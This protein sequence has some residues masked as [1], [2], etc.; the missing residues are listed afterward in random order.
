MIGVFYV[1]ERGMKMSVFDILGPVMVGPSSSHTA[2]AVNIG[3]VARQVFG[4]K[5]DKAEITLYGS[6]ADTYKG[7]GTDRA[8]VAGIMGFKTDD[9]RI[10][11]AL[12][13]A[14]EE[15]LLI[16][17]STSKEGTYH[18]NTVRIKLS[19]K[20]QSSEI[21]GVSIGGGR[22]RIREV[23]KFKVDISGIYNTL[24]CSYPDQMG[25]IAKVSEILASEK[26]NIATMSVSR[27]K[28]YQIALMVVEVDGELPDQ[29]VNQ[30]KAMPYFDTVKA[31]R[32]IEL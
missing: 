6:F 30:I 10:K 25:V 23:D 2:G 22:V 29:A 13:I 26:I 24:L 12:A 16:H 1:S 14:D 9:P 27:D 5:P 11:D 7:H 3:R 15:G 8:L 18:P 32:K 31:I 20:F 4:E 19:N 28:T 17:F 21:V